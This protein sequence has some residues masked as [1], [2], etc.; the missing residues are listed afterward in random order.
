LKQTIDR[1][2]VRVLAIELG[3]RE[4]ARK[5]GLK[6]STV[7]SWARRGDWKLPKR[8]GDFKSAI[9]LHPRAAGDALLSHK[10]LEARA[11]GG[12]SMAAVNAAEH[13]AALP[14]DKV[15]ATAPNFRSIASAAASIFG[16]DAGKSQTMTF[17]TMVVD[18]ETLQRIRELREA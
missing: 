2:S 16:W 4:T 10:E 6:E 5:L 18:P 15:Y 8:R 11:K 12:L 17:N 14:P 13:A 7:L 9:R 1:E 3:A